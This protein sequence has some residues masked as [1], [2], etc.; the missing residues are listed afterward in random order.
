M[1]RANRE[2]NG[3]RRKAAERKMR[4]TYTFRSKTADVDWRRLVRMTE[5][6]RSRPRWGW[7]AKQQ[8]WRYQGL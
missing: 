8:T 3:S 5:L 1:W 2:G 7:L 6:S 4:G